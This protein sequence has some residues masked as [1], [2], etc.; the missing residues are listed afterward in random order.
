M[1][2]YDTIRYDVKQY[3]TIHYNAIRHDTIH[4]SIIRC[5]KMEH[6]TVWHNTEQ[7][8]VIQCNT[9]QMKAIFMMCFVIWDTYR[10]IGFGHYSHPQWL[11]KWY[12]FVVYLFMTSVNQISVTGL[13]SIIVWTLEL[14]NWSWVTFSNLFPTE[15]TGFRIFSM[16]LNTVH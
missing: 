14:V 9:V 16:Y 3:Y 8:D 7:Y 10:S 4:C 1:I 15:V 11:V 5:N 12:V 6:D 13:Y 2:W